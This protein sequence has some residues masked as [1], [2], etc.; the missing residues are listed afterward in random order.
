MATP[1]FS[2]ACVL[3]PIEDVRA[4]VTELRLIDAACV[5]DRLFALET[6]A[7]CRNR[8]YLTRSHIATVIYAYWRDVDRVSSGLEPAASYETYKS[9]KFLVEFLVGATYKE[10]WDNCQKKT[11][12]SSLLERA[13]AHT[14]CP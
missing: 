9:L 4:K 3:P 10:L 7:M 13:D 2:D 12:G 1:R 14:A 8:L 6:E 5:I 11:S